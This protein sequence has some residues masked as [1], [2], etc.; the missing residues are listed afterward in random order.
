MTEVWDIGTEQAIKL[1]ID[2]PRAFPGAFFKANPGETI[3]ETIRAN[4]PWFGPNGE[5]PFHQ[6]RLSPGQYYSRMARPSL[7]S[8]HPPGMNPGVG[9]ELNSVAIY[10][11]QLCVLA[12]QLDRICQTVHPT[13]QTFGTFGHDI[14]NLLILSC[15]EAEAHWR[16]VLKANGMTND[17]FTTA[18][19]VRLLPAMKLDEYAVTFPSY[20]WL[21]EIRPYV[22]WG[23]SGRP[24][25]DLRWY[26]SYN[27]AKHDRETSFERAT[28]RSVFEAISACAIMMAAEFGPLEGT[29]PAA[30]PL[31][32]FRLSATPQWP[33][34]DHYI[35]PYGNAT[36]HAVNFAF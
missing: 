10:H 18:D 30:E 33:L 34:A 24:T 2:N 16:G 11:S 25:Q 32:F 6:A 27:A 14:R 23:S 19:Y 35:A 31:S 29:Y 13:T 15:T 20:P 22:G 28:L 26:D 4:T 12:R 5:N 21:D 1:G 7:H 3:W 17:R 8:A 36:W 9:Q